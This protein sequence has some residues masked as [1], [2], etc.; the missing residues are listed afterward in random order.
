[1]SCFTPGMTTWTCKD[2]LRDLI[3]D[4]GV[5][6]LDHRTNTYNTAWSHVGVGLGGSLQRTSTGTWEKYY[7]VINF[8]GS[9]SE[10]IMLYFPALVSMLYIILMP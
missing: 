9:I 10:V 6:S 2:M 7:V 8:G 5:Q 4:V 1:M 3:V